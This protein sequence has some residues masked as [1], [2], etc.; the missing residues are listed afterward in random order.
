MQTPQ[1][2]SEHQ[3]FDLVCARVGDWEPLPAVRTTPAEETYQTEDDEQV[4]PV[5]E[6]ILAGL[7]SPV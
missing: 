4:A 7:V 5:D 1:M 6:L 3:E 2:P